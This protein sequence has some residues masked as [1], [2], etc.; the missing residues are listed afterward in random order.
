MN[1]PTRLQQLLFGI[2]LLS[3]GLVS[4]LFTIAPSK[5]REQYRKMAAEIFKDIG[6]QLLIKSDTSSKE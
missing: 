3:L 1:Y 4:L 2:A 6:L 5:I